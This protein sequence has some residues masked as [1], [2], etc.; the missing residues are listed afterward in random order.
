MKRPRTRQS[1]IAQARVWHHNTLRGW[2][3]NIEGRLVIMLESDTLTEEA[4][5][6]ARLAL[7]FT[8]KLSESLKTR[9]D[10]L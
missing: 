10:A 1:T 9:K 2:A 4:R 5:T 8:T 3:K 6:H 7:N